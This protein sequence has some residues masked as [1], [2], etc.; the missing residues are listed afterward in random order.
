LQTRRNNLKKNDVVLALAEKTG[1]SKADTHKVLN[2]LE[3][4]VV[5]ALKNGDKIQWTGFGTWSVRHRAARKG[6]NPAT[7]QKIDIGPKK[8]VAWKASPSLAKS[9]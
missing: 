3:D 5:E 2:A 1:L 9:V 7:G 8:S 4:L 6:V